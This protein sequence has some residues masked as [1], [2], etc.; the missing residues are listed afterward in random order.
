MQDAILSG[1]RTIAVVGLSSDSRRDSH[2]VTRYVQDQ[3]YRIVPVNPTEDAP[4]L[5]EA[6]YATLADVP[7]SIKIDLVNVFRRS[8]QTDAA[9]DAALARGVPA[10]W[11]QLGITNPS[12]LARAAAQGLLTVEDACLMVE[13]TTVDEQVAQ[14]VECTTVEIHNTGAVDGGLPGARGEGT[15]VQDLELPQARGHVTDGERKS[16][17]LEDR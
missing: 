11:L 13:L 5:G 14:H 6:V 10:V 16:T 1:S 9:I 15:V 3:G 2:R 8:S 12:G 4:I 17:V 7:E